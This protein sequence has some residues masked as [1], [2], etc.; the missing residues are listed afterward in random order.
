MKKILF[1]A[2][3]LCSFMTMKAQLNDGMKAKD[4]TFNALNNN[5]QLVNLYS[6]LD[7]GKYVFLDV[8]AT[9]C[10]PC[11]N[12]HQTHA[13]DDLYTQHGPGSVSND[14][15]V[16]W[17]D[18]DG[19]T[20][21]AQMAGATGSQGNW[22]LNTL[23]PMCNPA[24]PL[25]GTFNDDYEIGYFPTIYMICPDR[26]VKLVGQQTAVQLYANVSPTPTCAAKINVDVAP[27]TFDGK[28]ISCTGNFSFNVTIKNRGFNN[29]TGATI[30]VKNGTTVLSTI[31]WTGN[32]TTYQTS[33]IIPVNLTGVPTNVDSLIFET[34][35][36]GDQIL[37]NNTIVVKIDN[38]STPTA[39]NLP[40]TQNFD[41]ETR[42]PARFGYT[43]VSSQ[44]KFGFYDGIAGTTKL[45]GAGGANTKAIF[46]NFYNVASGG[47]G[48]ATIG[49]FNTTTSSTYLNLDFDMAYAQYATENDKLE[50]VVS[51]DC[52]VTWTSKW[53]KSGTSMST[54][55]ATT[56]SFIPSAASQWRHESVDLSSV[57]NNTNVI[58][59]Y[60]MTSAYGNYAWVD[61]I[62]FK[63]GASPAAIGNV[64]NAS[65]DVYPNPTSSDLNVRGLNGDA[66]FSFVDVLGRTIKTVSLENIN[67]EIKLNVSDLSKGTYILKINNEGKSIV[68]SIVITE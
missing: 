56:S 13:L 54:T 32:L 40:L 67:S 36:T 27:V 41:A 60:R 45:M 23:F 28:L 64:D 7:S 68:K 62:N 51:T 55:A 4:F 49:N 25:A 8:S 44:S 12:Y 9:W 14:V 20:T 39:A 6:W 57:K 11:W 16:V 46:V 18:G 2:L 35:A 33:A 59:G 24:N 63:A 52:G 61:N 10:G 3:A 26:T 38:Y 43:D 42:M 5:G 58:V 31:P 15:R 17:V 50:V 29:L 34:I 1:S 66:T 53:T 48:I 21:D 19:T 30:N 47:T 37:D 65:V 22:L